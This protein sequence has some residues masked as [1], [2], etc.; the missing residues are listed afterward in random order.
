VID[1][2]A[3]YTSTQVTQNQENG[4]QKGVSVTK[5]LED[6]EEWKMFVAALQQVLP[7]PNDVLEAYKA[8]RGRPGRAKARRMIEDAILEANLRHNGSRA[9]TL[10]GVRANLRQ[11]HSRPVTGKRLRAKAE[12][13]VEH[14]AAVQLA[15]AMMATHPPEDIMPLLETDWYEK[16]PTDTRDAE[17][18][19]AWLLD[20]LS[21]VEPQVADL[22]KKAA[23]I[24]VGKAPGNSGRPLSIRLAVPREAKR[25]QRTGQRKRSA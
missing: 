1:T 12:L 24:S 20:P 7:N 14:T 4:K 18:Y 22:D 17:I 25:T 9:A 13:F 23:K 10:A 15:F 3:R 21:G 11:P 5:S 19:R 2:F 8:V 16:L 6:T